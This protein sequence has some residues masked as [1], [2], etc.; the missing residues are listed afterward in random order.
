M[1]IFVASRNILGDKV[2]LLNF[3]GLAKSISMLILQ[4]DLKFLKYSSW[5]GARMKSLPNSV[6][7]GHCLFALHR[8]PTLLMH[9]KTPPEILLLTKWVTAQCVQS[10]GSKL[11]CHRQKD[12]FSIIMTWYTASLISAVKFKNWKQDIAPVFE[13]FFLIEADSHIDAMEKSKKNWKNMH[14]LRMI[15]YM[16]DCLRKKYS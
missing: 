6:Q 7:A 2:G 3:K 10:W 14:R 12:S 15:F 8:P 16:L 5:K 13:N 9:W 11:G 1:R 4:K